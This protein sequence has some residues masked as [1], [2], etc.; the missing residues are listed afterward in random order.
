LCP[1]NLLRAGCVLCS[2]VL[3]H[4]NRLLRPAAAEH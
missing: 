3:L 4:S 1:A 2:D